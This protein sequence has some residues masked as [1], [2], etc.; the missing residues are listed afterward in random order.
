MR[1]S[2]EVSVVHGATRGCPIVVPK[3]MLTKRNVVGFQVHVMHI[4]KVIDHGFCFL[5]V[6]AHGYSVQ[7]KAALGIS[8]A[9]DQVCKQF[10]ITQLSNIV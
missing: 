5:R 1:Q 2:V 7:C 4:D 8:A 10:D 3:H 9:I 6:P